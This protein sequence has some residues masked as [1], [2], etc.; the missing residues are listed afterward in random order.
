MRRVCLNIAHRGASGRYPENT[1][2]AFGAAIAAGADMCELDVQL[3]RD[4]AIVVMHDE[5][6]DRTTDGRGPVRAVTIAEIKALN[7]VSE[8]G[9]AITGE[10]VP[11]L[12]EVF[13]LT[14]GR[15]ALNIELK[16]TGVEAGV[17][18]AMR[19]SGELETSIVS[20]FEWRALER[21]REIEP[22]MRIGLLAEEEPERMIAAAAALK[23]F[24]INPRFDL[25]RPELCADAHRR[26]LQVYVWTVDDKPTMRSLIARG[27]DGIMSNYPERLRA[28]IEE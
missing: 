26:G 28:V 23:A 25:A 19:D 21:V 4:D 13:A 17:C 24:A 16:G 5:K 22:R 11:T 20:S 6:L 27:V 10:R 15:C 3:T 8:R 9:R 14:R 7:I 12:D 2:T 1:L 18:R